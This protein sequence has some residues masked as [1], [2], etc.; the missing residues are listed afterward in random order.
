MSTT[1]WTIDPAHTEVE[2]AVKHMMIATVKGRFSNIK[3]AVE[4]PDVGEPKVE[5]TIGVASIDTRQEQR[6]AHLRS[7]DFFDVER[8]PEM[9]FVSTKTESAANGWTVTGEL[10]IKGIT[11][12]VTL[13]VTNE[14]T[15]R[16]PWGKERMG[17]TASTK[18]DR[19]E[20]GLTWNAALEAGG[21][22]VGDDIK[23]SVNGE[24]VKENAAARAA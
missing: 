7:P 21:F 13:D 20:F 19:R 22:L 6:D 24:L 8:Y 17:V 9:R 11:R 23:I 4:L 16:D 14:G 2:F 3:G 5:V 12:T 18:V 10:T 1:I 15:A